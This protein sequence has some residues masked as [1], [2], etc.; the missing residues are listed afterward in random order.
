M[1]RSCVVGRRVGGGGVGMGLGRTEQRPRLS[2]TETERGASGP[3][4]LWFTQSH[5]AFKEDRGST[6]GLCMPA[7]RGEPLGRPPPERGPGK[8]SYP[9]AQ[10]LKSSL[11]ERGQWRAKL[12]TKRIQPPPFPL[13]A[14]GRASPSSPPAA[15][16]PPQEEAG[17]TP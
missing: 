8:P 16:A 6:P 3:K 11:V 5:C 7:S 13:G 9:L 2:P 4:G 15:Q 17:P 12:S 1:A 14:Q 10:D